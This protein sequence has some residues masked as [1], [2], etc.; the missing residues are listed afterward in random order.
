MDY[1]SKGLKTLESE[2]LGLRINLNVV[3][4]KQ[5][6]DNSVVTFN[7]CDKMKCKHTFSEHSG[8]IW[9][10]EVYMLNDKQYKC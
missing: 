3:L 9:G 4:S 5:I 6:E 10:L 2:V 8:A 1:L 7:D